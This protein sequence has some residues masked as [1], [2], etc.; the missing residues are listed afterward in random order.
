MSLLK[1]IVIKPKP[2][3]RFAGIAGQEVVDVIRK[4][5]ADMQRRLAGRVIWNVNTTATGGGVA[6]LLRSLVA[7][8]NDLGVRHHNV[9]DS[10]PFEIE[11]I[12]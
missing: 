4:V 7:Y 12:Q 5:A 1:D 8:A 9:V 10:D 3:E 11:N 6:E 2:L